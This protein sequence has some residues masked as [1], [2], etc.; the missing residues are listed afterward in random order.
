MA[1]GCCSL[2]DRAPS[3]IYRSSSSEDGVTA[4][5]APSVASNNATPTAIH[6][7][8]SRLVATSPGGS[9]PGSLWPIALSTGVSDLLLEGGGRRS[10]TLELERGAALLYWWWQKLTGLNELVFTVC[11]GG[12]LYCE[13]GQCLCCLFFFFIPPTR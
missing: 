1:V 13:D 6:T 7:L 12:V 11:R 4:S 10:R 5:T 9:L 2:N 3:F 8:Q